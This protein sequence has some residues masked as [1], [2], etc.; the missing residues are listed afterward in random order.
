MWDLLQSIQLQVTRYSTWIGQLW[1]LCV[2]L[3]RLFVVVTIGGAVYGDELGEF[4]CITKEPGCTKMCFNV[5]NKMSHIRFWSFQLLAITTPTVFFHFFTLSVTGQIAKKEAEEKNLR[6][7]N[8][9]DD[10]RSMVSAPQSHEESVKTMRRIEKLEKRTKKIGSYKKK[11]VYS[12]KGELTEVP[13]TMAIHVAY[14]ISIILRMALEAL[15]IVLAYRL[16]KFMDQTTANEPVGAL[17]FI[18][19]K[20]PAMFRCTAGDPAV[21]KACSQ[22]VTVGG[23]LPCW[24]SRP[25]EKTLLV[26][27]MNWLSAICFLL[28]AAEL[29]YIPVRAYFMNKNKFGSGRNQR[30]YSEYNTYGTQY[31]THTFTPAPSYRPPQQYPGNQPR[32][33]GYA[34]S[35]MT[36]SMGPPRLTH[37]DGI[38]VI[39]GPVSIA[40]SVNTVTTLPPT[41]NNMVMHNQAY[42]R[43]NGTP[44]RTISQ[45]IAPSEFSS[46][47]NGAM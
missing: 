23:V 45:N 39:G 41:M 34:N 5:F 29:I 22:V 18:N 1:Y 15:F 43:V 21:D 17:D 28:S 37:N 8:A 42:A 30:R 7:E 3:F 12:N 19:F 44:P 32:S 2:F 9:I 13:Y 24:I 6:E 16:F 35:V 31:A 4:T 38:S 33:N 47:H 26:R 27:Y 46:A 14:Y 36:E 10:T 11:K 25:Y 40:P 20:V